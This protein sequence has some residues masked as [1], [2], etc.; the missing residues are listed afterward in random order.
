MPSKLVYVS[1]LHHFKSDTIDVLSPKELDALLEQGYAIIKRSKRTITHPTTKKE[2]KVDYLELATKSEER[3][4]TAPRANQAELAL[5]RVD[6]MGM[7]LSRGVS[8]QSDNGSYLGGGSEFRE[9]MSAAGVDVRAGTTGAAAYGMGVDCAK[10]QG[11]AHD[12]PFDAGTLP[13]QEWHKGF[14][15]GGGNMPVPADEAALAEAFE[16]GKK[17]AKGPPDLVVSCPFPPR[18]DLYLK[19]LDG[20]KDGGGKVE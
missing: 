7:P 18:S 2:A 1:E 8:V 3:G 11:F 6:E 15:A 5:S 4:V 20:F 19:W 9:L 17:A 12:C 14:Q 10:T 13:H 16:F